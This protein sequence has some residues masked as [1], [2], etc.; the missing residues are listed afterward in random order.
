MPV[1]KVL[2]KVKSGEST[3]QNKRWYENLSYMYQKYIQLRYFEP[4]VSKGELSSLE[5]VVK[6]P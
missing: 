6:D 2:V 4:S 1:M 3:P 5:K